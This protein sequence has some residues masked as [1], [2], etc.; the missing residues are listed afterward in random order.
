[1][2]ILGIALGALVGLTLGMLGGGGAI[3][4]VPIFIYVLGF[5]PR[6]AIAMSLAVVGVVSLI[7]AA[8]H[9]RAGN[10]DLRMALSF[11][12]FAMVGSYLGTRLAAF[13]SETLQLTLFALVMLVAAGFMFRQRPDAT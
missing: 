6:E 13:V 1:M 7:G 12:A 2:P 5:G 3:L 4:T 10:T 11:G 8:G 9:W